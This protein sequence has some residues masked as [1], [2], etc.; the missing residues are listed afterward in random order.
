MMMW[1][2]MIWWCDMMITTHKDATIVNVLLLQPFS[3]GQSK[4]GYYVAQT[5]QKCVVCVL[6]SPKAVYFWRIWHCFSNVS[7]ES[8]QLRL[9]YTYIDQQFRSCEILIAWLRMAVSFGAWCRMDE[10]MRSHLSVFPHV[11]I[12]LLAIY[13]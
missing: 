5:L 9:L 3:L 13:W 12:V 8:A 4:F 7:E 1:Y 2:S 10:F 11:Y 6:D